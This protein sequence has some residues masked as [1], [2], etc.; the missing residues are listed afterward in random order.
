MN[1]KKK[2]SKMTV[3]AAMI[4]GVVIGI[5]AVAIVG[6]VI[7]G[8]SGIG[9][10]Q[11]VEK[12]VA[13]QPEKKGEEE[14]TPVSGDVVPTG[15]PL[16]MVAKQHGVFSSADAAKEFIA[17]DAA[18]AKAAV[19]EADGQFFVWSAIGLAEDELIVS[20]AEGTFRKPFYAETSACSAIGAGKL[21]KAL[22]E[23]DLAQIKILTTSGEGESDEKGVA[24]FRKNLV[25]VTAFTSDLQV[26]RLQL[27]AHYTHKDGCA[28]ISF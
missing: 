11:A 28:K 9:K 27:L 10:E 24:D 21:T 17:T 4:H 15:D 13:T 22:S 1:F 5:A 14:K 23:T 20:E 6:F 25:A 16:K 19:I 26:I 7:V 18:L 2:Y 12:G 8:T 3:L